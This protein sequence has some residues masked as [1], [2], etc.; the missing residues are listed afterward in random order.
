MKTIRRFVTDQS[1]VIA[2]EY[3]LIAVVMVFVMIGAVNE[4][5]H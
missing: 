1:T 5:Q 3:G 4:A 2:L